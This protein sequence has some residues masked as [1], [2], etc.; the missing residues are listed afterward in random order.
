MRTDDSGGRTRTSL[1]LI[2]KGELMA[3]TCGTTT[4][5]RGSAWRA[6]GRALLGGAVMACALGTGNAL[7]EA[8]ARLLGAEGIYG[9]CCLPHW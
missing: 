6:W 8:L 4:P 2:V 7:G 9:S 5:V 1:P 3:T